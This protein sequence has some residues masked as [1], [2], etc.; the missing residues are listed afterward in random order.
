MT[1]R[2]KLGTESTGGYRD[3]VIRDCTFERSRGLALENVDGGILENVL[4]ENL[5]LNEVT[6]APIFV[7]LGARGRGPDPKPG[8]VRN[9][10]IRNLV[11]RDILPDYCAIIAGL[12]ESPIENV[13]LSDIHLVYRGGGAAE[14]AGRRPGDL[15][16]AYPEPSMFGVT[17]VH[18]LWARHVRGLTIENLRIE[19]E[20]PDARPAILLQAVQDV[21]ITP[22]P[23]GVLRE[24]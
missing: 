3:I 10:V 15:A 22:E 12:P 5:T 7:R 24:D 4:C 20:T 21:N 8:V 11:A 2:I 1:G 23:R 13:T 9:I 16:D 6:T 19:T 14:D 17:P 18:G